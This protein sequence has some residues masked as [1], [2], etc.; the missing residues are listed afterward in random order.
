MT[1]YESSERM[2]ELIDKLIL[3]VTYLKYYDG[4]IVI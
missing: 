1:S 2:L 3:L 4:P